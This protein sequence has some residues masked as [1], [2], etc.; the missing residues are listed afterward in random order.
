MSHE[1]KVY[2]CCPMRNLGRKPR[3]VGIDKRKGR[4]TKHEF[5]TVRV[6]SKV[7]GYFAALQYDS[8]KSESDP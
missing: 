7:W 3:F 6:R 8:A 4:V 2:I 1:C 5:A